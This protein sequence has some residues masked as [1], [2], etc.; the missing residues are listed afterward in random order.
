[1]RIC[2]VLASRGEGGLERHVRDLSQ[3]LID[4]GHEVVIL[5]D[6]SI[7]PGMPCEANCISIRFGRS[8][9]NP[10]LILELFFKLRRCRC[11]LVHAHANKAAALIS[12]IRPWL[13]CPAVG[14]LHN[15]KR[16]TQAFNGLDHVIAVS[17][18]AAGRLTHPHTSVIL[19]GIAPRA[20]RPL[21]LKQAF[22]L[23][24]DLP[25]LCAVGRL[26]P[27][28]GFDV[29]LDAVDGLPLSLLIAGDG[30]ER[31]LL[32]KRIANIKHP[33]RCILLGHRTDAMDIMASADGLVISSRHE[34]FPYVL[35]EALMSGTRVLTTD[36]SGVKDF[37]P[38]ELVAQTD[39][40]VD[41][42]KRLAAL[43]KGLDTWSQLMASPWQF[44][45]EHLTLQAM[46]RD[47]FNIYQSLIGKKDVTRPLDSAQA[48]SA[49]NKRNP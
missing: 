14:T 26:V 45:A 6:N 20:A 46:T 27:A 37:F 40:V 36:I 7:I 9:L 38:T 47:T 23:P 33:T 19:N 30:P 49:G 18:L 39:D 28:K 2:Q 48:V 34:G 24:A 1:M 31:P 44:A 21:D 3:A 12:A 22:Q 13:R 17:A 16:R 15:I 8:R 29:L 35:V 42:R 43:V 25:V 10:L 32:E 5:A 41:L 4:A 11:D